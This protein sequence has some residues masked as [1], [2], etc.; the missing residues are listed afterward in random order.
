VVGNGGHTVGA[1]EGQQGVRAC[2]R[3]AGKAL[4]ED[5]RQTDRQTDRRYSKI[6]VAANQ[7]CC[8]NATD[9]GFFSAQS[10][11]DKQ[12]DGQTYALLI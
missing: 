4:E 10:Q 8:G 1:G 2:V 12:A 3:S 11:R 9:V 7:L 5:D 6:M